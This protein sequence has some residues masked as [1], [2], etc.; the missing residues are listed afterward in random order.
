MKIVGDYLAQFASASTDVTVCD[1][2]GRS[3]FNRYYYAT[4]L[5]VRTTLRTI[6]SRWATPT[7]KDIPALLRGE[8]LSRVKNQVKRSVCSKQINSAQA[9]HL[10]DMATVATAELSSLMQHARETRRLADYEP[11]RRLVR[12]GNLIKLG[13]CSI[14]QA[15]GWAD[16]ASAYAKTILKVYGDL[17]LI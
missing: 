8:V 1:L 16:R 6:D 14:D 12:K 10:R 5:S 7:H 3:A 11:E 15:K 4:F 9:G 17:G 13:E 2:F